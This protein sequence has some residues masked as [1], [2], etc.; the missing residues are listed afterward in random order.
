MRPT[1]LLIVVLV[2]LSA[3]QPEKGNSPVPC[4]TKWTDPRDG[5]VYCTTTIGSQR[6]L[7]QNLRH[8][9]SGAFV[10]PQF[11]ATDG[12]LYTHAAALQACPPGWHLPTDTEW[13]RLEASLGLTASEQQATG[14]RGT[15]Q[16][17]RLK[18]SNGWNTDSTALQ[19][20][21]AEDFRALPVGEY[22]PSYGPYFGYGQ[23]THFWS[24]TPS[25]TS[26]GIWVRVLHLDH[27]GIGRT[28]RS[29]QMGLACRCV[30]D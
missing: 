27:A 3:C 11:K 5:E 22:N 10:N 13:Q 8:D 2:S 4:T 28:Y 17:T 16:G 26:G 29:Q 19:S 12:R 7:A 9:Q 30:E 18:N 24:A 6:W 23:Q 25:D 1:I 21:N 20:T 15:D 14:Y